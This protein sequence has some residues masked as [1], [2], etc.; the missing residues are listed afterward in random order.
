MIRWNISNCEHCFEQINTILRTVN[1]QHVCASHKNGILNYDKIKARID[2]LVLAV[3]YEYGMI[4]L[5]KV[6]LYEHIV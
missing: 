5:E 6:S 3:T 4:V 2:T 1:L